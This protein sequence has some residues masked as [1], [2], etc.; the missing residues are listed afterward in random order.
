MVLVPQRPECR[1]GHSMIAFV[2]FMIAAIAAA[3][4]A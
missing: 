2:E 1:K 4:K 3:L